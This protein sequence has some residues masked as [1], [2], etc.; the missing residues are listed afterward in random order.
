M[1]GHADNIRMTAINTTRGQAAR[2]STRTTKCCFCPVFSCCSFAEPGGEEVDPDDE[3][4][5][6]DISVDMAV[7]VTVTP[8]SS[9]VG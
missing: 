7:G 9:L 2:A 8:M 6:T 3:L 1:A 5:P 4:N